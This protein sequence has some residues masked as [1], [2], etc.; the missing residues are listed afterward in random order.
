MRKKFGNPGKQDLSDAVRLLKDSLKSGRTAL[1]M[2]NPLIDTFPEEKRAEVQKW[3]QEME[4]AGWKLT[5]AL[6]K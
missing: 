3:Y 6:E 2:L 5:E 1:G 4:E